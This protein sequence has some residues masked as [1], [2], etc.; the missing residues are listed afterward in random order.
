MAEIVKHKRVVIT[1]TGVVTPIGLGTSDFWNGLLCGKNGIGR[2]TKFDTSGFRSTLAA[3]VETYDP[4]DWMG[5]K[6]A[7]RLDR[8]SQFGI[9]AATMACEEAELKP[10]SFDPLRAGIAVGSGIGGS[11]TIEDGFD[12]LKTKGA[13]GLYASF[14]SRLLINM[15]ASVIS[16]KYGLKGPIRAPSV[17]CSTGAMA[18][19][20]AFKTIQYGDADIM[21][22]GGAEACIEALPYA[23]FCAA[24]AMSRSTDPAGACRPFDGK[25]DG[26]VMGEGAGV[27]VLEEREHARKRGAEILAEIVGY[28]NAADAY[29]LTAPSPN[30]DGMSRSMKLALRDA[31]LSPRDIGYINAHGTST[32]MNDKFES[33]AIDTVFQDHANNLKVNSTKSMIGHLMAAAGAVEFVATILSLKHGTIHP[34]INYEFPDP[35][36][37]HDYVASGPEPFDFDF[38]LTNSFGFG[39]GN[40]SLVARK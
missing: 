30:G 33:T 5:K 23:G 22:A 1:G 3:E 19:G 34:T 7:T 8:F 16:I 10:G 18:I 9:S 40:V 28:G 26:F 21:L 36:C 32:V 17:A 4:L 13:K 31:N 29:H 20:D 15:A 39:G 38:A 11:R 12:V 35:D 14:I 25:R 2:I 6:E 27:I 37:T 24:R